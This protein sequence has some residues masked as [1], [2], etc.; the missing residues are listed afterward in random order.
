MSGQARRKDTHTRES[1]ITS[2]PPADLIWEAAKYAENPKVNIRLTFHTPDGEWSGLEIVGARHINKQAEE[3][4]VCQKCVKTMRR[5]RAAFVCEGC[6]GIA[7][8]NWLEIYTRHNQWVIEY[9]TQS[10]TGVI[11]EIAE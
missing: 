1:R 6:G 5:A 3:P 10:R 8:A 4:P 11:R 7:T 9:E 2:G